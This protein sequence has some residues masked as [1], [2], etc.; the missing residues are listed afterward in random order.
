MNR[1]FSLVVVLVFMSI[2]GLAVQES[3]SAAKKTTAK[4]SVDCSMVDD[5]KLTANVKDKFA[6]TKS[7]KEANLGVAA[8]TGKVTLTGKVQKGV[9][10]GLATRQA[11]RVPCV[12]DVDNQI[13]V[14]TTATKNPK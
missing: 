5:Q 8:R 3:R 6:S 4:E 14:E 1:V 7:L 11:K 2:V 13:T 9:T 12:K 10:K